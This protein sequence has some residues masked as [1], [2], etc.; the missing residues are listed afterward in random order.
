MAR[1][2]ATGA[3][4]VDLLGHKRQEGRNA[5]NPHRKSNLKNEIRNEAPVLLGRLP[6]PTELDSLRVE[7]EYESH[8]K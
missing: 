1:Y 2:H 5:R 6:T 3:Q 4:R 8:C 7:Y